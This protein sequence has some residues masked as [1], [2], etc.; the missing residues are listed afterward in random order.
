M[1][2]GDF[3]DLV[4]ALSRL[5]FSNC[6]LL[7]KKSVRHTDFPFVFCLRVDVMLMGEGMF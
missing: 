5:A 2:E 7:A 3:W 1:V 6:S 4:R